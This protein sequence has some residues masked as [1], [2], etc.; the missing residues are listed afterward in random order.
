MLR[1]RLNPTTYFRSYPTSDC[2][3]SD[4][5]ENWSNLPEWW[6]LKP[7]IRVIPRSKHVCAGGSLKWETMGCAGNCRTGGEQA[8]EGQLIPVT[9]FGLRPQVSQE[10]I[11]GFISES[12][13]RTENRSLV[14]R[15]HS[16]IIGTA[17]YLRSL[18]KFI[19]SINYILSQSK[20]GHFSSSGPGQFSSSV[21][22][23]GGRI[24]KIVFIVPRIIS[25]KRHHRSDPEIIPNS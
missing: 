3:W 22:K 15:R 17:D 21:T 11:V 16:I 4:C 1:I 13:S 19:S 10:S 5:L 18:N 20:G 6:S 14:T 24:D 8:F 23:R 12:T 7:G 25:L 9:P 2:C